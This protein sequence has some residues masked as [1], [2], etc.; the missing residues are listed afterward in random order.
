MSD[1]PEQVSCLVRRLRSSGFTLERDE[2]TPELFGNRLFVF[3]RTPVE[4]RVTKDRG[5]WS[6]DL[7]ADGWPEHDR[8]L[9]PL[10]HGFALPE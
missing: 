3:R 10:L 9:F 8:V 2:T 6:V 7:I 1:L 5:Q 4:L